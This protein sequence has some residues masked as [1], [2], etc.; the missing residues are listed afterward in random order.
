MIKVSA[1]FIYN[2]IY[3]NNYKCEQV[4]NM[5]KEAYDYMTSKEAPSFVSKKEWTNLSKNSRLKKHLE[6]TK[7]FLR[8]SD[9]SFEVFAD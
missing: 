7:D 5:T 4:M 6:R 2:N 8:A 1:T 9:F 3:F